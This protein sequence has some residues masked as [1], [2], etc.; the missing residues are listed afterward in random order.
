M[1]L[2]FLLKALIM[3]FIAAIYISYSH[4]FRIYHIMADAYGLTSGILLFQTIA[5]VFFFILLLF[6]LDR[7]VSERRES[8]SMFFLLL[9]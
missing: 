1:H 4:Y 2:Y 5:E 9:D 8:I 6:G 7:R 3:I